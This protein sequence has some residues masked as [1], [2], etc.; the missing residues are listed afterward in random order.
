ML[1]PCISPLPL[2]VHGSALGVQGH[3]LPERL[4]VRLHAWHVLGSGSEWEEPQKW[5]ENG[6]GWEFVS[7]FG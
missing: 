2:Q 7:G 4:G 3:L 1:S 6:G 5:L